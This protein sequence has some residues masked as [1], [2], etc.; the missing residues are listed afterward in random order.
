MDW[1]DAVTRAKRRNL[2]TNNVRFLV[3]EEHRRPNLASQ[4]L[5]TALKA[6]PRH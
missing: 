1:R 5:A 6:Q 2:I 3:R 4:S